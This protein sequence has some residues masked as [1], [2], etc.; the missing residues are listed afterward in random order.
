MIAAAVKMSYTKFL[1]LL[2]LTD[3]GFSYT[4]LALQD[5]NWT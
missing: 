5:L 2:G 4:L 3:V 1:V